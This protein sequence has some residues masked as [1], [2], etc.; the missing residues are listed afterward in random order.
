[1]ATG[2]GRTATGGDKKPRKGRPRIDGLVEQAIYKYARAGW[3]P[4]QILHE[5]ERL[6][7][8]EGKFKGR[9][10]PK[11]RT[12]ERVAARA[13]PPN[14][15]G[16]WNLA[17]ENTNPDDAALV[18]PVL[19]EAAEMSG[20]RWQRFGKDLAAWVVKVRVAAPDIPPLWAF[21]V[22]QAYRSRQKDG[23]AVAALDQMLGF[24]PW[25]GK[26]QYHRYLRATRMLHPDWFDQFKEG[27]N[28]EPAFSLSY[29]PVVEGVLIASLYSPQEEVSS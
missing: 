17:D 5:L 8:E 27:E 18:L 1:M 9:I 11:L 7:K 14:T 21:S 2:Q 13:V 6:Q 4:A 29:K 23:E 26:A 15:S 24:A 28:G 22:A 12:F 3:K 20:G 25:Q 10:L 16:W 19:A